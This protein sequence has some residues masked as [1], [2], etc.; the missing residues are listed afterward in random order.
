M[1][2]PT[3]VDTLVS[4]FAMAV[5]PLHLYQSSY[6]KNSTLLCFLNHFRSLLGPAILCAAVTHVPDRDVQGPLLIYTSL[7][8][9]RLNA[10]LAYAM[11]QPGYINGLL[12][13][14][15]R[16]FALG[17]FVIGIGFIA[18]GCTLESPPKTFVPGYAGILGRFCDLCIAHYTSWGYDTNGEHIKVQTEAKGS[19]E[20]CNFLCAIQGPRCSWVLCHP[21]Q[22]CRL[23]WCSL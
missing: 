8:P 23:C 3:Y 14:L 15:L 1:G 4:H 20:V 12:G 2:C 18:F 13:L 17:S 11:A 19:G 16:V 21:E 7:E 6:R 5:E 22:R 10:A 9:R